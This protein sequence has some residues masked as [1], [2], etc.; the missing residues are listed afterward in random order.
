MSVAEKRNIVYYRGMR[1]NQ[2]TPNELM[3]LHALRMIPEVGNR[4]LAVLREHFGG[5]EAVWHASETA[6]REIEGIRSET[7]K[8]ALSEKRKG[9]DPKTEWERFLKQGITLFTPDHPLYPPLLR[10]IPDHPETLYVRGSFDWQ[11]L[12]PMIAIVGSRKHSAYGEQATLRLSEDL[13]RAGLLVVSGLAFGIDSIAH[14][15]ALE[16]GGETIAVLGN[17]V[18]DNDITPR[19]HFPLAQKILGHGAL[20]SEYPPDF[21]VTRWTFPERDRII[22]GLCLGTV[23]I[24]APEKS[25]SLIT[26]Q[27]ALDYNRDVFAIPGS[28]FSPYSIGTNT[29][30]K[31]GAK[32]V[33]GIQDILEELTS[34]NIFP[35]HS[36]ENQKQ[37]TNLAE[38]EKT[39]LAS[40]SHEP[41]HIDAIIKKT[42]FPA[43]VVSS[44]LALLEIKGL[45]KNV[46]GMHYIRVS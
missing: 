19:S 4:T 35:L 3:Y 24:E 6:I 13:T 40:L 31:K 45:A 21:P 29:L 11:T 38:E 28:I 8:K 10:E 30:I 27:C 44:F 41:L 9:I 2:T 15:A 34:E 39:L 37:S 12:P 7:A 32:V 23:V 33:T 14:T 42:K 26:A 22:A 17:G 25:G 1:E 18:S 20:V 46:G 5:W 36:S 16:A 43:P